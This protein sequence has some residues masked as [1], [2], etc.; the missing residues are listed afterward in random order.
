EPTWHQVAEL[1]RVAAVVTEFQGHARTC[2]C[3]QH[4]T[5]EAIP[6]E[7][8]ADA[9]GPRLC[10]TLGYLTGTQHVSQRGL[11]EVALDLF[12]VP[13][14]LGSVGTMQQDISAAL[15][16]PHQQIGEEVKQAAYKNVD[17]TSWKLLSKTCWLW[18]AT[19]NAGSYFLIQAHR[20]R[21]ELEVLLGSD[22]FGVIGSDRYSAYNGL[23]E[24]QRQL[25]WA[26]L[27]RDFQAMVDRG[28]PG[29]R[30]GE[31]LLEEEARVFA[32]W[33]GYREGRL[34]FKAMSEQ[35]LSGPRLDVEYWLL[36][37][38]SCGCEKTERTCAN[39]LLWQEALWT[40]AEMAGVEPANNAAERVLRR[41][42][43][44]RKRSYG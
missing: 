19:S 15:Q 6:A 18:V 41:A 5:R 37:G 11:E 13:L 14:S 16:Q 36:E 23:P 12:G 3:C 7:I 33:H 44:R 29:Q 31:R 35:M 8:T 30:I 40:F 20:G 32:L 26:H 43:L 1:P 17:E 25:C 38:M 27:K 10:A 42:V 28:G 34:S 9:F 22:P 4:V 2:P 39:I 21:D 24:K